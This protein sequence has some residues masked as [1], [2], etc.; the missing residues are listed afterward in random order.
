MKWMNQSSPKQ[1]LPWESRDGLVFGALSWKHSRPLEIRSVPCYGVWTVFF[2]GYHWYRSWGGGHRPRR[3]AGY[4]CGTNTVR[5]FR[6][7]K[8]FSRFNVPFSWVLCILKQLRAVNLE[9][10]G[11]LL[12][13]VSLMIQT[14]SEDEGLGS[15]DSFRWWY[16]VGSNYRREITLK[17]LTIFGLNYH[18][19]FSN[20]SVEALELLRYFRIS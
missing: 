7:N 14:R 4:D 1:S 11:I 18:Q 15:K 10:R 8:I 12:S 13:S 19:S 3:V 5:P 6:L 16:S 2:M 9:T 17:E 20:D